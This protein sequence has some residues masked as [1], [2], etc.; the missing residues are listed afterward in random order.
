MSYVGKRFGDL[1]V[2]HGSGMREWP[3]GEGRSC[4]VC[5]C[6]VGHE[7]LVVLELV[8]RARWKGQCPVCN[9][10]PF[11]GGRVAARVEASIVPSSKQPHAISERLYRTWLSVRT[12][13]SRK[14]CG[15]EPDWK[16][17]HVFCS[18]VGD[19]PSERHSLRRQASSKG[20]V[21]GNVHWIEPLAL[22]LTWEGETLSLT[23]WAYRKGLTYQAI[24]DRLRRGWS[25]ADTLS[26]P[27]G[28]PGK[29]HPLRPRFVPSSEHGHAEA[30]TTPE[31][32]PS[33]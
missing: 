31:G 28:E 25:T 14:G 33:E 13:A 10:L 5:E 9:D 29:P 12:R 16:D 18:D 20:F 1:M 19:P 26:I 32:D 22:T 27:L 3:D 15:I 24:A 7:V 4:V 2:T 17:F 23:E 11:D 8:R 30:T 6:P 21:R